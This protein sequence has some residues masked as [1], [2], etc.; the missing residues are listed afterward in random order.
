MCDYYVNERPIFDENKVLK[1]NAMLKVKP[2]L[3]DEW[4]FEKNKDIEIYNVKKASNNKLWWLCNKGHSYQTKVSHRVDGSSCPYCSNQKVLIGYND[5]W[6][7]NKDT[8]KELLNPEDG[9]KYTSGSKKRVRWK[10]AKKGHEWETVVHSRAI[11]KTNCPYCSGSLPTEDNNLLVKYPEICKYWD[12]NNNKLSPNEYL[13]NS[14]KKAWWI[15]DKCGNSYDVVI[16]DKVNNN[17]GNCGY[18]K[19]LKVNHTNSLA[20]LRPEIASEWHPTKNEKLSPENVVVGSNKK[21]WWLGKCG[22]EWTTMVVSRTG[23]RNCPYCSNQKILIGFNDMRT[24]NPELAKL[25][26]NP[27]DGFKYTQNSNKKFNWKCPNC[28][29]IIKNKTPNLINRAGL[30]CP[31]CSDGFSYPEKVMY[32]LL[33][34]L[35]IE[36]FWHIKFEWSNNKNYDFHIPSLNLIIETHGGQHNITPFLNGGRTLQEEQENDRYKRELALSNGIEHYIEIDCRYSNI[37]YIKENIFDSKI[38]KFLDISKIDWESIHNDSRKSFYLE[39][40][41]LRDKG[42]TVMEISKLLTLNHTTVYKLFNR[43]NVSTIDKEN[44]FKKRYNT[45]IYQLDKKNDIIKIWNGFQ[46]IEDELGFNKTKIRYACEGKQI[47]A[48]GFIWRYEKDLIGWSVP[49]QNNYKEI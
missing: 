28:G 47:T 21:V 14:N 26:L 41:K 12:Y 22:H 46:F 16:S 6:T 3:F 36:F 10:C 30:A 31:K 40:F 27:E 17:G 23:G 42:H 25:L 33:K 35:N 37:D 39:I 49:I 15:C 13:P 29:E 11:Y 7:T 45:V 4:D 32:N 8:A 48:Y 1:E 24:T 19:G 44:L 43:Y 20:A 34:C 2:E 9:Y 5:L 38:S 18:C